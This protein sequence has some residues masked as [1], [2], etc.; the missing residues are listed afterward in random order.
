MYIVQNFG[1]VPVYLKKRKEDMQRAQEEYDAYIAEHFRRGALR[2]LTDEER[3]SIINGLKVNWEDIHQQYQGLSV[4]TDTLPKKNRK[5][6]MEAQMKQL[7]KDIEMFE[8]FTTIYIGNWAA[9]AAAPR[10]DILMSTVALH[11]DVNISFMH[12]APEVKGMNKW[13]DFDIW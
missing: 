1:D 4:V 7:E 2:S 13:W 3:Q 5:E 12:I 10:P 8:K 9:V 11:L 6:R